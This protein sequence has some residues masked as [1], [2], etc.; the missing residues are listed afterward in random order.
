M[1]AGDVVWSALIAA[2]L[3]AA[4]AVIA[5]VGAVRGWGWSG[6]V[7]LGLGTAAVVSALLALRSE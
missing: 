7:V 5:V 2:L 6:E 3:A 4:C 1:R